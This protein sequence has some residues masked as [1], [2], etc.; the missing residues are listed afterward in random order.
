MVEKPKSYFLIGFAE[1]KMRSLRRP[2]TLRELLQNFLFY[3]SENGE[4]KKV[5]ASLVI[6]D[7]MI[8]WDEFKIQIKRNDKCEDKLVKE[9]DEWHEIMRKQE[10]QSDF[11]KNKRAQFIERLDKAFDVFIETTTKT[12]STSDEMMIS[13]DEEDETVLNVDL[14]QDSNTSGQSGSG[15][16]QRSSAIKASE[17]VKDLFEKSLNINEGKKIS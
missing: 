12:Q 4:T 7:A 11:Q 3:H 9:Y 16:A 13:E 1:N 5:A 6:K 2:P 17:S 10:S 8:L 15:V 14:Q